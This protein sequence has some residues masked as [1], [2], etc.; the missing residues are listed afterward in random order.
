MPISAEW[1]G[2]LD[3]LVNAQIH[4]QVQ[5]Y[6]V[7]LGYKE[8]APVHRG[9]LL[10]EIDPRPFKAALEQAQGLLAQAEAQLGKAQLDVKRFTPLVQEKAV[11]REEL[12]DAVQARLAAQ[13]QVSSAH[14]ALEEAQL[15]LGF[16]RVVSPV[17]GIAGLAKAQIGDLVGPSTGILTTVSAVDPIKAYFPIS[18]QSYL[19]FRA[20]HA[21]SSALGDATSFELI[22]ADGSVYPRKGTF[23]A[24]DNQVDGN[25]GTLRAVALFP[26]PDALL[27]PGQFARVRAVVSTYKGALLVPR[28]VLAEL[29]GGYQLATVDET[30]HAH[31]VNVKIGPQVGGDVVI[32][33]GIHQGDRIVADGPQK[34]R[35]GAAVN[36]IP[37]DTPQ[38]SK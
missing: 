14:G 9:D 11:S 16:T 36:P 3:G 23:Y 22:L 26:N 38:A 12:D 6:I 19:D 24:I 35:E 18:E 33:A 27:R 8:G 17:D 2:S 1:V 25:T 10:F 30:N 28:R 20:S 21:G 34:I 5:G 15:A 13:A 31:I 7:R 29:Q 32:E 4:A 37:L